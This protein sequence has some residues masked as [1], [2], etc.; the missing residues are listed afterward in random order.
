MLAYVF[1]HWPNSGVSGAGYEEGLRR[2][3][4]A[5]AAARPPGW[6]QSQVF[7]LRGAPWTAQG[8]SYEEWYWLENSAAL[9]ALNSAAVSGGCRDPHDA[10]AR[11]VAGGA[12]GLYRPINAV[13]GD[14]SRHIWFSK[15]EGW[16]YARLNDAMAQSRPESRLWQRQLVLGPTPELC[17][18]SSREAAT[19]PFPV[20]EIAVEPVWP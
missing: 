3:Q 6:R 12:A 8:T 4:A 20:L 15:P 14:F 19:L 2:F 9:D 11:Q 10:V 18:W 13:Q 16:S 1:W 5:L 7:R 17:L